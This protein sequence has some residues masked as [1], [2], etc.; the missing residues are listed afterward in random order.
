M[1]VKR[2]ILVEERRALRRW[3]HRQRPKPT[4]KQC[5]EWFFEQYNH[6]LS[7]SSVSESLS[8][9]FA[10]LDDPTAIISTSVRV[11]AGNWPELEAIL[12]QWQLQLERQGGATTGDILREQAKKIWLQ[13]PQATGQ[14]C[15]EFSSRWLEKFKKRHNIKERVRHG[16]VGSIPD[17]AEVEMKGLQ[18]VAGEY[19]EE[20]IYNMDETGLYWRMLVSRGLLSQSR[21]SLKKD[22]ARI[23]LAL[24]TNA[25]GTDRLP[26]WIIGKAKTPRALKNVCISSMGGRW[27]WNKKAWMNS[28]IMSEWLQAF[29][30]HVGFTRQVLLTMDN[31]SAHYTAL[32]I[33]PP[34]PNIRIC[35]LPANSTSRFQPLNQGIIQNFKALYKRQWL[36]FTLESYEANIDPQ[37]GMNIR[38]AIRWILR[39]WNNEVTNTTIYNCF[40][41]STLVSTS[42][43]LSTPILPPG[44]SELY[45]QVIKTGN[46]Q[47]SMAINNFLNPSDEN[48]DGEDIEASP[49]SILQGIIDEHLGVPATNEED[50]EET[51]SQYTSKDA[52]QAIQVLIDCTET[53]EGLPT[54]HIRSLENLEAI[55]KNLQLQSKEQT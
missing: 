35:W 11:R 45:N 47:D 26:V 39:S 19:N 29:Y 7:Q 6:R 41:R 18:T 50:D 1:P 31:F 32:E 23:S 30:S 3:A 5:I 49:D 27:R 40:R 25:T 14:E 21:P 10:N 28:V 54:K 36:A 20:D 4:H 12:W 46:I 34:P 44:I 8:K 37:L 2:P 13:L 15:P 9:T 53:I 48:E 51:L 38:L 52:L 33:S 55:F 17:Q 42:L 43:A 22:K 24:C 16:E